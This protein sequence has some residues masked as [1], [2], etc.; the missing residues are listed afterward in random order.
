[1]VVPLS[2]RE[3]EDDVKLRR[4]DDDIERIMVEQAIEQSFRQAEKR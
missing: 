1:M 4:R 3:A 2:A